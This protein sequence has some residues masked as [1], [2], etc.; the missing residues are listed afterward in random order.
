MKAEYYIRE[1]QD[2]PVIAKLKTNRP[3]NSFDIKELEKILWGEVGTKEE[4]KKE[5]GDMPL[6]EL[7]RSIVGLDMQAA[8]EAFAVFLENANLDSRQ[9]YFINKIV[10]YIVQNGMLKDFSVLQSSPFT[11]KG[12]V[13]ELFT[14][15]VL[16]TDI[17]KTIE[18]INANALAA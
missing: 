3:L 10:E 7:V 9:I 18:T 15:L 11:D 5:Y 12:N 16:W 8:K 4:Y 2:N 6:G 1:N 13:A 14:D 17:K